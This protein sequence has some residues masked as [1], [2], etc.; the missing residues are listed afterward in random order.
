V[1]RGLGWGEEK[2]GIVGVEGTCPGNMLGNMLDVASVDCICHDNSDDDSGR[3]DVRS[4]I[5]LHF[6]IS[7]STFCFSP[8]LS[9]IIK[10]RRCVSYLTL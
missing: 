8:A 1:V 6:H 9:T 2:V 7:V 5:N 3:E 4:K 10:A